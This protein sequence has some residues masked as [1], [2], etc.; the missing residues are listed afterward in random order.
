MRYFARISTGGYKIKQ[1]TKMPTILPIMGP[2]TVT[3]HAILPD[4]GKLV[5]ILAS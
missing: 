5:D 2:N 4:L 1:D 3:H